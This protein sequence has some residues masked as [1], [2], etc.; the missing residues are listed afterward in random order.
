V[1]V[2]L[3]VTKGQRILHGRYLFS[4]LSGGTTDLAG[5][6]LD[7]AYNGTFPTGNGTPGSPFNALFVNYG[8]TPNVPV[9]TNQFVPVLLQPPHSPESGRGRCVGGVG[10]LF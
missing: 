8:F 7:G 10:D 4:V 2:V 6:R 1:T 3:T 5:N 9:A